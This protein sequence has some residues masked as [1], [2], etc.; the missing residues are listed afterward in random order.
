MHTRRMVSDLTICALFTALCAIGAF[1]KIPL[2]E[3]LVPFTLQTLFVMLSAV[4]IGRRAGVSLLAYLVLGLIG[5]PIF[6]QGGGPQ[7][8]LK[9]SFGYILGFFA[10]ALVAGWLIDRLKAP[11][12]SKMLACCL[13]GLVLEYLFGVVHLGLIQGLYL[14]SYNGLWSLLYT[15][16]IMFIPTDVLSCVIAAFLG[17]KLRGRLKTAGLL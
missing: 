3:P 9:P 13:C 6:T 1:I 10:A 5:I 4:L 2:P 15:G 11:T 12:P 8:V 16:M 7:Y 14:H 17:H